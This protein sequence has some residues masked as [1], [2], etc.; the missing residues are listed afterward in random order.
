V[1]Q[2]ILAAAAL[3]IVACGSTAFAQ[4]SG[5]QPPPAP[6]SAPAGYPVTAF[7]SGDIYSVYVADPHRPTNSV[8]ESF[9]VGGG[10]PE[11]RSPLT[12]VATG[13]RFGMVRF[14]PAAPG[15]RAWQISVE[16]GFDA[17]F[18]SQN[19]LDVVGWDGNYG[20]TV[21]T[22]SS[23]PLA[24]KFGLTHVSSHIGDE[25]LMRTGRE[26]LNYTREEL[27]VGAAWRWSPQWRAYSE[28]GVAY[29]R[30]DDALKPWRLQ[31]GVEW[32]SGLGPC[33]RRFACY[34]A[35]D[36]SSM[37]ERDWRRDVTAAIGIVVQSVGRTSRIFLEWHDGRPTANEFYTDTVKTL[38]LGLRMDL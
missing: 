12:Q 29:F 22:A 24:W 8:A 1:A 3:A 10:I 23:S 18:D 13:G 6:A 34:A 37:Q 11:T 7:P 33:G 27:N 15:G 20:L 35:A 17:L 5:A 2:R 32:D 16:A 4:T 28:A 26:R 36:L 9:T 30:G 38:S 19:K 21:T 14:G 25:Y 31:G